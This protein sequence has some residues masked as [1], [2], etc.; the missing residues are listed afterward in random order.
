MSDRGEFSAVVAAEGIPPFRVTFRRNVDATL[1][2]ARVDALSVSPRSVAGN[3]TGVNLSG[4]LGGVSSW[5]VQVDG[6]LEK[7]VITCPVAA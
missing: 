7:Q 2:E 3:D 6:E 4:F 5:I 1:Q